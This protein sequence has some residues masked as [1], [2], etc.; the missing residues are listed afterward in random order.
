MVFNHDTSRFEIVA[1]GHVT[2]DGASILSDLGAG[3]TLAAGIAI[4]HL[5]Q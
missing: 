1:T 4:A 2:E 3:L 5:L